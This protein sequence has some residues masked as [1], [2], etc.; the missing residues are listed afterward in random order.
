MHD[1]LTRMTDLLRGA[2]APEGD[3]AA[4]PAGRDEAIAKLA[5]ALRERAERNRRQRIYGTLA[6]AAGVMALVG[7]GVLAMHG[8]G[9]GV[10]SNQLGR[11]RDPDVTAMRDGHAETLGAGTRVAEGTELRTAQGGEAHLDFDT[12]TAVTIESAARVRLVE[13]SKSKRFALEAGSLVAK[14]AKLGAG[15]RFVVVTPDAEIEVRGTQFRVALVAGDASC[16]GGTPTRLDVTEGTVVVRHGGTESRVTAGQHWP[17]CP[18]RPV[19]QGT[20]NLAAAPAP[21]APQT[22]AAAPTV[23]TVAPVPLP[24]Q[25]GSAGSAGSRLSEQNDLFEQA[26][27]AKRDGRSGQALAGFEKFLARYPDAPLAEGAAAERMRIL[28]AGDRA[29]GAAAAREYL[30]HWPRGTARV[31]AEGLA[32]GSP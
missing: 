20:T 3:V 1:P 7:G 25:P 13:Q 21:T 32:A 22:L 24:Q 31:E 17:S 26:M 16:E 18:S 11:V 23:P 12:G 10:A 9:A 5:I 19:S 30:K 14:V 28:A 2:V 27:R 4:M 8:Q 6:V 15:E 29:R